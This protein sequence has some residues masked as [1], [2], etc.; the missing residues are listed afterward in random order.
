MQQKTGTIHVKWV[1]SGIA[2]PRRQKE[3]VASLGLRRLNQVVELPDTAQVRGVISRIPHLLQVVPAPVP[4]SWAAVPEYVIVEAEAPHKAEDVSAK[5]PEEAP[6]AAVA[7][8]PPEANETQ[9]EA[10]SA[11]SRKR[12]GARKRQVG[13]T[14]RQA[15]AKDQDEND[16][17]RQ[18]A[19]GEESKSAEKGKK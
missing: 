13:A 17:K 16:E 2:F 14:A 11:A 3:M 8:A 5:L 12:V 7:E 9:V 18:I 10:E 1:R 15:A 4:P 19:E 6:A